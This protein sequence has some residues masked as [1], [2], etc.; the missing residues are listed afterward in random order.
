MFQG[1][2]FRNQINRHPLEDRDKQEAINRGIL[3]SIYLNVLKIIHLKTL[4]YT[5]MLGICFGLFINRNL[6]E[7]QGYKNMPRRGY[8]YKSY[9]TKGT[10]S[11][12]QV[13]L[14]ESRT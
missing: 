9:I 6:Q 8:I 14:Q 7:R 1:N 2:D 12:M 10:L 11:A 13:F 5:D 3:I 4:D